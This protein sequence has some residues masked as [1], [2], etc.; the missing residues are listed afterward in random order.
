[1]PASTPLIDCHAHIYTA[2]M[3]LAGDA[4]H[5]P[6]GEATAEQFRAVTSKAGVR[7]SV[8][9]AASIYGD[10]NDYSLAVTR[11]DPSVRTTVIVDPG[12]D[13]E[14]LRRMTSDGAVGLRLQLRNRPLPDIGHP[15][16]RLFLARIADLGW[17]VELHDDLARL[18]LMIA[19]LEQSEIPLVIDHFGR[20]ESA[21][22]V[23]GAA[24]AAIL[25]A[26]E[27]GRTWVKI[28]AA[29]RLS[30]M[31]VAESALRRLMAAAGPDRLL[32]GSDWPFVG[33]EETMTYAGAIAAYHE[34]VPDEA[35]RVAIDRTGVAFYFRDSAFR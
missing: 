14:V 29:F 27:R 25:D 2:S 6:T 9:A 33:F 31:A 32:W 20:P 8:L 28:S 15:A 22:A 5:R 21:E 35:M 26:V 1:M 17:H 30:S 4:W 13:D 23:Q 10:Y 12:T 11:G 7:F 34:L 16:F 18:P 19:A 3:P 24:F